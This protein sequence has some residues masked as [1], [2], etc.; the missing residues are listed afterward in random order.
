MG[1]LIEK[2]PELAAHPCGT[3]GVVAGIVAVNHGG[4]PRI[5][6]CLAA[7]IWHSAGQPLP[8]VLV[9]QMNN[10]LSGANSGEYDV[11]R[12]L[13]NVP[14]FV[15]LWSLILSFSHIR[16]IVTEFENDQLGGALNLAELPSKSPDIGS[17]PLVPNRA[18]S[19][20][21]SLQNLRRTAFHKS[22]DREGLKR[23]AVEEG[24]LKFLK[25]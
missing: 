25:K 14:G 16:S 23:I 19:C 1:P 9:E 5:E 18:I 2:P 20:Q 3:Q 11:M 22:T 7:K 15:K 6:S 21:A 17:C 4:V 10:L 13:S 24:I 8:L 12:S